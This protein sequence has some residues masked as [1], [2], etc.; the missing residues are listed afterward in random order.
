[1][2]FLNITNAKKRDAIVAE[3]LATKKRIKNNDYN[4]RTKDYSHQIAIKQSLDPVV[5]STNASTDAITKQL[6][7]IEKGIIEINKKMQNN[8][9]IK[10]EEVAEEKP[11]VKQE[12]ESEN[13]S[14]SESESEEEEELVPNTWQRM[15]YTG[16]KAKIDTYF[17]IILH[18]N[19]YKM[20]NEIV[21]MDGKNDFTV[22][23]VFYKGTPGLWS[24]IMYKKP[25]ENTYTQNDMETYKKLV[26]QTNVIQS[27]N[28]V[29]SNSRIEQTYKWRILFSTFEK[30]GGR[31]EYLP[32]DIKSLQTK[33]SYLLA[34]SQAG[35]K[36]ATRNKIIAI[37][38]NLLQRNSISRKKYRQIMHYL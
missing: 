30:D 11:I 6:I 33:L 27:P 31:I 26:F 12:N 24:L 35:N 34:T 7:P 16:N 36:S 8:K 28:N 17:G 4:E 21:K 20:G 14:K 38:D 10:E 37:A 3:Y 13:E 19:Q 29:R 32:S 9:K 23:D 25:L 1:M 22:D 5:Q 15:N 18:K 2:S